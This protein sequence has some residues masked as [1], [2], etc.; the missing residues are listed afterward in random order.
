MKPNIDPGGRMRRRALMTVALSVAILASVLLLTKG[1]QAS[2]DL[3]YFAG[4]W[5]VSLRADPNVSFR[6]EVKKDIDGSWLSG[7]V[8]RGGATITRDFWRQNGAALDR[9]AFTTNGAYVQISS[10]GWEG[11]RLIFRGTLSDRNG[12]VAV[13]ETITKLDARKFT[14]IWERQEK[15]GNWTVFGDEICTKL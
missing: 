2:A 3:D 15:D 4:A 9:Y 5:N 8:E 7:T 12:E 11:T 10:L 1:G 14:A 13:R 6:W